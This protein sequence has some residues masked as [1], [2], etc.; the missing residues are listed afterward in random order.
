MDP[1]FGCFGCLCHLLHSN[2]ALLSDL[3]A[4]IRYPEYFVQLVG[5]V[6]FVRRER[7]EEERERERRERER[8]GS[9]DEAEIP[10]LSFR[11]FGMLLRVNFFRKN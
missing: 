3:W 6:S 4:V 11:L 2:V 9:G 7:G 1:G 8:G 10:H 5:Q